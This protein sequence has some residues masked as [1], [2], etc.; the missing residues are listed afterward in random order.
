MRFNKMTCPNDSSGAKMVSE[1][2]NYCSWYVVCMF[3]PA[4]CANTLLLKYLWLARRTPLKWG[5][6]AIMVTFDMNLECFWKQHRT[7]LTHFGLSNLDLNF[8]ETLDVPQWFLG[9]RNQQCD[10]A[11]PHCPV[12]RFEVVQSHLRKGTP[13]KTC[14]NLQVLASWWGL[15]GRPPW[16]DAPFLDQTTGLCVPRKTLQGWCCVDVVVGS[17]WYLFLDWTGKTWIDMDSYSI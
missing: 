8:I 9:T 4:I 3:D 17:D 2:S 13:P 16:M 7:F 6:S 5:H 12:I 15:P 11:I 14:E 1:C 10:D